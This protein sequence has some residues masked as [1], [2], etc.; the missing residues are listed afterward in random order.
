MKLKHLILIVLFISSY[1]PI[2]GE[3]LDL[4]RKGV[5]KLVASTQFGNGVNWDE[6]FY[7]EGKH[8][9]VTPDGSVFVSNS[10]EHKIYKFNPTGRLVKTFGG[11]GEG[12]GDLYFPGRISILDGKLLVVGEYATRRRI[13]L[14][15]FS[16]KCV[17]VIKT[18]HNCFSPIGLK[19]NTIA[20]YTIQ[21]QK[22][23]MNDEFR[24]INSVFVVDV[25]TRK[26]TQIAR[27]KLINKKI[28]LP[29]GM[30][31][32]VS[33]FLGTLFIGKTKRGNLLVGVNNSRTLD[34]YSPQ[35]EFLKTF[36]LNMSPEAIP[37]NYHDEF[38]TKVLNGIMARPLNP[39]LLKMMKK[40][41]TNT[42]FRNH[43][44]EFLPFYRHISMDSEGNI[45]IFRF[46]AT[47][48]KTAEVFQVYS[49]DTKY[50][51]DTRID[52]GIFDFQRDGHAENIYFSSKGIYG[53]FKLEDTANDIQIRLVK[54]EIGD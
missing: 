15:N 8:L 21:G 51:C 31:L 39:Q 25:E 23:K 48:G 49:P 22:G 27:F 46:P 37:A 1:F 3:L 5:V 36:N 47:L 29:T 50:V 45:L 52:D 28:V 38:K 32:K 24:M 26:E 9:I 43:F 14:F 4:Y 30:T 12:P 35:G 41:I 54:T 42:D 40:A 20:Y 17:N 53:L 44:G 6:I 19:N 34:I 7:N 16:G 10:S 11:K 2:T 18:K 33:D 13:S